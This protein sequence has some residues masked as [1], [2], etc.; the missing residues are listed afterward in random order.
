[1]NF[2]Q[3]INHCSRSGFAIIN[4]VWPVNSA[5]NTRVNANLTRRTLY[6][7]S[8]PKV[9]SISHLCIILRALL[10]LQE[11]YRSTEHH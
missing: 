9:L 5:L 8:D 4:T 11:F 6:L 2:F 7:N 1:M 10:S 3:K